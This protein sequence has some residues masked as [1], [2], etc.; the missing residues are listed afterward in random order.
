VK[1][2]LVM[3]TA[4]VAT[5]AAL[6]LAACGSSSSGSSPTTP[7]TTGG[8]SSSTGG[9]VSL[10][11]QGSSFQATLEAQWASK[12]T[13]DKVTY[14]GTGS[15][16]G[17]TAFG[18]GNAPFAG[19]DVTMTPAQEKAATKACGSTAVTAPI[20]SGGVAILFNLPN[21]TKLDLSPA[22]IAG[23]F[24]GKITKWN[25]PAIAADNSGVT[26]PSIPISVFHR[27]DGSGTTAVLTGFLTA[28]EPSIW[29]L[30]ANTEF[31][32]WPAG[33]GAM[34]SSGVATGVKS[35]TGA[36]GYAETSYATQDALSFA[37]VKG[38]SGGYIAPTPANVATSITSGFQVTGKG[39]D[40][41]GK[42]NFAKMTGYPLSTVSYVLFCSK[43]SSASTGA[44]VKGYLSYAAGAGQSEATALGFAPLPSGLDSQVK[45]SVASIS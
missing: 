21:I 44:A 31:T 4:G 41:S 11:P 23:I 19:S 29:T 12:Y 9:G 39:N 18:Q 36:I 43:Y 25:D 26:L 5:V 45:T 15:T 3:R 10:D 24:A 30:G 2:S 32:K 1:V 16:A 37:D 28:L 35:T 42:L 17:I 6:G 20:T 13:A 7:S 8:S 27:S 22:T 33:Q 34:G 38:G 40:L 14:T